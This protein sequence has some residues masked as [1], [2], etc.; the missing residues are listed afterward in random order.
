MNKTLRKHEQSLV[1]LLRIIKQKFKH[2]SNIRKSINM[3]QSVRD[4][5]TTNNQLKQNLIKINKHNHSNTIF[6][7]TTK[8]WQQEL[9]IYKQNHNNNSLRY[10]NKTIATIA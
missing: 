9:K 4:T 6:R 2:N 3:K 5:N 1:T 7:L 8:P 10:T